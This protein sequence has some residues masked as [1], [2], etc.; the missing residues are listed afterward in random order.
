MK[1]F[2]RSTCLLPVILL[3]FVGGLTAQSINLTLNLT[4][5]DKFSYAYVFDM[6]QQLPEG[7]VKMFMTTGLTMSVTGEENG[8]KV[9]TA[10][11]D[12]FAMKMDAGQAN[13]DVDTKNPPPT[14]E[15]IAATPTKSMEKIFH[16]LVGQQFTMLINQQ[17]ELVKVGG[18]NKLIDNIVDSAAIWFHLPD[19][20]KQGMRDGMAK[21][22]NEK[23]II[24]MMRQSFNI[25]PG[26]PVKPGEAWTKNIDVQGET[27]QKMSTVYKLVSVSGN[28]ATIDLQTKVDALSSADIILKGTQQGTIVVDTRTGMVI[29]SNMSQDFT[30]DRNGTSMTLKSKIA[31]SSK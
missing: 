21:Q 9:V 3:F 19:E 4:N 26:K 31:V 6:D 1:S 15:D 11:Y 27:P 20:T 16:A 25:L 5:G 17:G 23:S 30:G 2:Y 28:K 12:R 8:N 7:P 29:S 14:L 10:S 24:D 18:F 22:F 13:F